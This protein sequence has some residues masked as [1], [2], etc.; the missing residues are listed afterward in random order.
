LTGHG[1]QRQTDLAFV[2]PT[3]YRE[4]VLRGRVVPFIVATPLDGG[5]IG[6]TLDRRYALTL[7]TADAERVIPFLAN[8]IAI[9]LGYNCHPSSEDEPTKAHPFP[10]LTAM[11]PEA[12]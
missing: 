7:T 4:I 10:R 5:N 3:S 11:Y 6:L 1:K 9:A 2:G 12:A 8:A